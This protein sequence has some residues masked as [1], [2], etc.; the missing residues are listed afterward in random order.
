MTV[1]IK[2]FATLRKKTG[3]GELEFEASDVKEAL[4]E[5]VSEFEELEDV[6]FESRD[7]E[8]LKENITVI[9]DGR[10]IIYLDGLDTELKPED[11]ISVFPSVGGG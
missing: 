11:S 2:L 8:E 4:E 9:K 5:L 6:I 1:K 3:T 10:N 7:N